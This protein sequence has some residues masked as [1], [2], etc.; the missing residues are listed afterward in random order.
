M[1]EQ[2]R[3][4]IARIIKENSDEGYVDDEILVMFIVK[5]ILLNESET[6][7]SGDSLTD[8]EENELISKVKRTLREENSMILNTIKMQVA[9]YT[10]SSAEQGQSTQKFSEKETEIKMLYSSLIDG[11]KQVEAGRIRVEDLYQPL[12]NYVFANAA[13]QAEIKEDKVREEVASALES[14]L[15]RRDLSSIVRMD[16]QDLEVQL[17]E[18]CEIVLGIRLFHKHSQLG[19]EDLLDYHLLCESDTELLKNQIGQVLQMTDDHKKAIQLALMMKEKQQREKESSASPSTSSSPSPS[20]SASASSSSSPSSSAPTSV[21]FPSFI[22]GLDASLLKNELLNR[23]QLVLFLRTLY[24]E[25]DEV[26]NFSHAASD[27]FKKE[28]EEV[29]EVVGGKTAIP[30]AQV[31][32]RFVR[33]S[34]LWH[35]LF[36]AFDDVFSLRNTLISLLPYLYPRAYDMEHDLSEMAQISVLPPEQITFSLSPEEIQQ[37]VGEERERVEKGGTDMTFDD[38]PTEE[39]PEASVPMNVTHISPSSP[40]FN[41][42]QLHFEGFCPVCFIRRNGLLIEGDPAYGFLKWTIRDIT[43]NFAFTSHHCMN[44]FK[45]NPKYF[46]DAIYQTATM[47]PEL[48]PVLALKAEIPSMDVLPPRGHV[49]TRAKT[50][51]AVPVAQP[52]ATKVDS[53]TQTPVHFV[54]SHIDPHYEWNEWNLRRKALQLVQLKKKRTH[55]TQTIASHFRREAETQAYELRD[56]ETNTGHDVGVN[57]KKTVRYLQNLR[58]PPGTKM[59]VVTLELQD[60][61]TKPKQKGKFY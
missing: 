33:L 35:S 27:S 31:Y 25:I 40:Q 1:S 49:L 48:I 47:Q 23:Q 61:Q 60:V 22:E 58:G 5:K 52:V 26:G 11:R 37:L 43:M 56:N 41:E 20:L 24:T 55:S 17:K 51:A 32:P 50:Y 57:P 14:V 10:C 13:P 6:F 28:L 2:L 30:K 15:P 59:S 21:S 8:D 3:Q 53:D 29:R 54:E 12:L 36:A 45:K 4:I 19:S 16:V 38:T 34:R 7:G 18:L 42:T 9:F 39:V 46:V 44:E